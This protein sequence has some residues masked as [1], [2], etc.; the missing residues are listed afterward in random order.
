MKVPVKSVDEL[1]PSTKIADRLG[2][3]W[4]IT[5]DWCG[6][7]W[8][9]DMMIVEN[10]GYGDQLFWHEI[11]HWL[12][13]TPAQ[14]KRADYGIGRPV[15]AMNTNT[16]FT[17]SM[18]TVV[19]GETWDNT[20]PIRDADENEARAVE[21]L[22][23]Y[24]LVVGRFDQHTFERTIMT[25]SDFG[26]FNYTRK[27]GKD[28]VEFSYDRKRCLAALKCVGISEEDALAWPDRFKEL[29]PEFPA[30]IVRPV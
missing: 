10:G 17:S 26:T 16:T 24:P 3:R 4:M 1:Y 7:G 9:G 12:V 20:L 6:P 5:D 23:W 14:R 15:N 25:A 11:C 30:D 22:I 19:D 13:A 8:T 18:R 2:I 29:Y 28:K 21:L 27:R